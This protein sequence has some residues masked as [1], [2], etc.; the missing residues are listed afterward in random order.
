MFLPEDTAMAV[1]VEGVS[2]MRMLNVSRTQVKPT[3]KGRQIYL[4]LPV[5]FVT[6]QYPIVTSKNPLITEAF[7]LF[8]Q[9]F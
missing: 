5:F 1:E 4:P 8:T 3:G 9:S 6:I 7:L 2:V